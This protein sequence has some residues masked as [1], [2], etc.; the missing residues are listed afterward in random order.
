M[1][2]LFCLENRNNDIHS[3]TLS[4]FSIYNTNYDST[5]PEINKHIYMK[6]SIRYFI[7]D[8]GPKNCKKNLKTYR[9]TI[10]LV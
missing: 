4:Y 6:W 5:Q 1:I 9:I 10:Y 3:F 7:K 8:I 2:Y